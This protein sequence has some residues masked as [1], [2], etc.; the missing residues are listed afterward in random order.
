MREEPFFRLALDQGILVLN[1]RYP[2]HRGRSLHRFCVGSRQAKVKH[3]PFFYEMRH[4]ANDLFDHNVWI[5]SI[6][7]QDVNVITA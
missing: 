3:F 2:V 4:R 6:L 7:I 5:G 1:E